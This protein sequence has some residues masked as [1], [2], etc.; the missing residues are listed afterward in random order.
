MRRRGQGRR[1]GRL[2]AVGSGRPAMNQIQDE[3]T[4][5]RRVARPRRIDS[6]ARRRPGC[7]RRSRTMRRGETCAGRWA[8]GARYFER[9]I[10]CDRPLATNTDI[11]RP[12]CPLQGIWTCSA[13]RCSTSRRAQRSL[14]VRA[15]QGACER[16]REYHACA[17]SRCRQTR[18]RRGCR[19]AGTPASTSPAHA[20]MVADGG[21]EARASIKAPAS[22]KPAALRIPRARGRQMTH[23]TLAASSAY[24]CW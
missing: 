18:W 20:Y 19:A 15:N 24:I 16:D 4:R 1:P 5:F 14:F 3:S 10:D 9:G 17:G 23:H 21:V 11:T 12:A 2:A 22:P 6:A 13:G 7:P 8:L